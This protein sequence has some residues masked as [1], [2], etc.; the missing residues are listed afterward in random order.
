MDITLLR[1][2]TGVSICILSLITTTLLIFWTKHAIHHNR[3]KRTSLLLTF[4]RLALYL[5]GLVCIFLY[6]IYKIRHVVTP[7]T[8]AEFEASCLCIILILIAF[9]VEAYLYYKKLT[10]SFSKPKDSANSSIATMDEQ[11]NCE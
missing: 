9:P 1:M 4:S 2:L 3:I 6:Y 7:G 10:S 5:S 8:K 11:N